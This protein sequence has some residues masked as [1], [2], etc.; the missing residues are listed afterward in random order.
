MGACI[1]TVAVETWNI[2]NIIE[3][4][5]TRFVDIPYVKIGEND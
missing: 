3:V 1:R 2:K 4:E 5:S